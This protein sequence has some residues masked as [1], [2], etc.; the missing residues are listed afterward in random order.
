MSRSLVTSS[1]LMGIL[2]T[3]SGTT[4]TQGNFQGGR[5]AVLDSA[6]MTTLRVHLE[7]GARANWH[8]HSGGQLLLVEKGRLR[9]Q[10]RGHPMRE[11]LRG[12]PVYTPPDVAHWHGAA[13][14]EAL[15]MLTIHA[16]DVEWH[17]PLSVADYLARSVH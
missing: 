12:E 7:A 4:G 9:I 2:G 5:P 13:P 3:V 6:D 8:T 10:L 15:T 11:V 17:E 14:D 16:G 1:V